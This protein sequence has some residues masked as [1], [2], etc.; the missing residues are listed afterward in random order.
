M[1]CI[2]KIERK[3]DAQTV[4]FHT[5][6]GYQLIL[7][8]SGDVEFLIGDSKFRVTEPSVIVIGNLKPHKIT[9]FSKTYSR[10]V[11]NLSSRE[12]VGGIKNEKLLGIFFNSSN[13]FV[14]PINDIKDEITTLFEMLKK[15]H[16]NEEK[17]GD[18]EGWL[19]RM[20]LLSLYRISP[21]SFGSVDN[22]MGD[23]VRQVEKLL[24]ENISEEITLDKIAKKLH[25][26][27]YYISHCFS[28]QV[29]YSIVQYRLLIK[30]AV[31]RELL[32]TTDKSISEICAEIGFSGMSNFSRYFKKETGLTPS[33]YRKN[34]K[35]EKI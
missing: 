8:L 29:G 35:R 14:I 12:T 9:T 31:A 16:E 33:E 1:G 20:I 3:S 19:L 24:H 25:V 21:Q 22:N 32:S 11:V 4:N 13:G 26:S 28:E 23:L 5:H 34:F 17:I 30:I 15:E 2:Q 6:T 18:S 27:K 7:M 10:Y